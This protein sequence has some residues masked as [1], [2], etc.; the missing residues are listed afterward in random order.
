MNRELQILADYLDDRG[1]EYEVQ[2]YSRGEYQIYFILGNDEIEVDVDERGEVWWYS[3]LR[4]V[5]TSF[6]SMDDLIDEK[7]KTW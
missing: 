6:D 5:F 7:L 3:I 4:D 1:W 2:E